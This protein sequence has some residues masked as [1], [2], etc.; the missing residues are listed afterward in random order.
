MQVIGVTTSFL[1]Q[2]GKRVAIFLLLFVGL[3]GLIYY[4]YTWVPEWARQSK[5]LSNAIIVDFPKGTR[6]DS[7]S[8][9]L[10]AEGLVD[11][12][13]L[14]QVWVKYF[15]DYSRFQA[16]SY[17][18]ESVTSP[19][20]I[21]AKMMAGDTFVPVVFRYTI[22]E[23]FTVKQVI[24]LLAEEGIASLSE[25]QTLVKDSS[26][27]ASFNIHSPSLEGYLYPATYSFTK[28]PTAQ[29]ALARAV[30]TFWKSLPKNYV[31]RVAKKGL[32]LEQAITI[33]SLIELETHYDDERSLVSEVIWRRLNK[34]VPLAIDATVI[35]GIKDYKGNLTRKHLKD[36]SNPYNS[37]VHRGLPPT[38]IG[39]PSRAS[40][41]AVLN[42][43][44]KG[45]MYYVLDLDTA[46]HHFSKTLKEHN[47]FVR[48][49]IKDTRKRRRKN[50]ARSN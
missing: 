50:A 30:K 10:E 8:Y 47:R 12:A 35:Y 9:S 36:T 16:G 31:E 3:G 26:F 28:M 6:L 23:G 22:P 14:F 18:F 34:K 41:E 4:A 25:L 46:K 2:I 32:S 43:S 37:R 11:N 5:S 13:L 33:A 19:S 1:V 27:R 7:L 48:K 44:N 39:S 42:P 17:R 38:P 20:L 40:L 15:S 21:A 29:E 49:L 24:T 45:Y